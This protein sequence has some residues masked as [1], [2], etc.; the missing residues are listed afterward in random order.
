MSIIKPGTPE[1][2]ELWDK[3]RREAQE[4]THYPLAGK[5]VQR[6]PYGS[7]FEA[8]EQAPPH[9]HDCTVVVGQYHVIGCDMERCAACGGQVISCDCPYD[10][11][12]DDGERPFSFQVKY[13]QTFFVFVV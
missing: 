9:C 13:K 4:Q 10:D 3:K 12:D 7:E 2:A 11:E 8:T 1:W 6:L 5:Q